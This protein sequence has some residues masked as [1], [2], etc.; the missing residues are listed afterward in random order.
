MPYDPQQFAEKYKLAVQSAQE[1]KPDGGLNGSS[2]NGICSMSSSVPCSRLG[3][4]LRAN[5]SLTIYVEPA[6]HHGW[7]NFPNSKSFIG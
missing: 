1:Q 2:L 4:A 3:L 5:R 7:Q 6:S